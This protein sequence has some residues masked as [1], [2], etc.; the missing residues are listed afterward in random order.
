MFF[1]PEFKNCGF[2]LA[3]CE[4]KYRPLGMIG[5]KNK[6]DAALTGLLNLIR[7]SE[8]LLALFCTLK[9]FL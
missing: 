7:M 9:S 5:K 2:C 3:W 4:G 6:T 8:Y 1:L